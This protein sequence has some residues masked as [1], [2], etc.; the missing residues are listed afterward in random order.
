[1]PLHHYLPAA[2]LASFSADQQTLPARNRVLFVAD[3]HRNRVFTARAARVACVKNLYTLADNS[4]DPG[5]VDDTW[6][7]Y[8]RLL[9][10]AISKLINKNADADTWL[11]V[12]VPFVACMLVR[13]PDFGPRFARRLQSLGLDPALDPV[14]ADNTNGARLFE[15]QRLLGPVV[16]AKWIVINLS[17]VTPLVTNDLGYAPFD[18]PWTGDWGLAIPLAPEHVL[19]IVPQQE[20]VLLEGHGS[21]W[22][23]VIDYVD[24]SPDNQ[25]GLNHATAAI[26]QRFIF[27]PD[28]EALSSLLAS[29]HAAPPAPEPAQMGFLTGTH[30]VAHEFTWHRLVSAVKK[31]PTDSEGWDFALDWEAI[32]AGWHSK[33][34]LPVNLL[35]FPPP[36]ERK[37][38]T[39]SVKFY[40]PDIYF[41]MSE[42]WELEHTGSTNNVVEAVDRALALADAHK[43]RSRL[44]VSR[45]NARLE[46]GSTVDA[47]SD[48][49]EA[50]R[51]DPS[52]PVPFVNHGYALIDL[53]RH[54]E[55]LDSFTR[56]IHLAPELAEAH[57]NRGTTLLLLDRPEEAID[58]LAQAIE[59][60]PDGPTRASAYLSRGIARTEL[61]AY[62]DA[63]RYCQMLW[64]ASSKVAILVGRSTSMGTSVVSG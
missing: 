25:I 7:A 40:N 3:K 61:N 64:I 60:L 41:A 31:P 56:A 1:M 42:I 22:V 49:D 14:C 45:G 63:L 17:G 6:A 12:L 20:R 27:G 28:K 55:A 21:T 46:L 58:D 57:L 35:E 30:A 44:L 50:I 16:A 39:I 26:A 53:A 43:F 2:F 52:N 19:A 15:L 47:L 36:L 32:A 54:Q 24:A 62:N 9:P 48:L 33:V 8:E 10:E 29:A 34:F 5:L 18:N 59:N 11:R 13:G 4:S 23:P 37:G 51:L 38:N